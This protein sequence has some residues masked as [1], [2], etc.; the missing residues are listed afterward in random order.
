MDASLQRRPP[1][2]VGELD[3][4]DVGLGGGA[5]ERWPVTGSGLSMP[6]QRP[7]AS[8]ACRS[9]VSIGFAPIHTA[10]STSAKSFPSMVPASLPLPTT[11]VPAQDVRDRDDVAGFDRREHRLQAL[12]P[13]LEPREGVAAF[14]SNALRMAPAISSPRATAGCEIGAPHRVGRGSPSR[15]LRAAPGRAR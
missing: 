6:A 4:D 7:P 5:P 10:K 14:C 9:E 12:Q 15:P 3:A 11:V 1:D 13:I 2:L 8:R